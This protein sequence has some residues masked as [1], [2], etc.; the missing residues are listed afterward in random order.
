MHT[1]YFQSYELPRVDWAVS[2]FVL[3]AM[4]LAIVVGCGA[5]R[6]PQPSGL[7]GPPKLINKATTG[8]AD[9]SDQPAPKIGL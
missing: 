5:P 6:A 7:I 2:V 9:R 1:A 8:P 3:V 4:S